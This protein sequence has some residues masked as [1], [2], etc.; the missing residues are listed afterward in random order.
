LLPV[1]VKLVEFLA[2][3]QY[4]RAVLLLLA[5]AEQ[6]EMAV[7]QHPQVPGS[8]VVRVVQAVIRVQVVQ[9]QPG[10]LAML[11]ARQAQAVRLVR[12]TSARAGWRPGWQEP[13]SGQ[14]S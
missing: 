12:T 9:V 10:T 6:A 14:V 11:V 2:P 7:E 1:A 5:P 13:S 3:V 4:Q 8:M